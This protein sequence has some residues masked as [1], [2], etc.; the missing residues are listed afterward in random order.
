MS[1]TQAIAVPAGWLTTE[2]TMRILGRSKRRVQEWAQA[3]FLR[4]THQPFEGYTKPQRVY[5]AKDVERLKHKLTTGLK[6]PPSTSEP[7]TRPKSEPKI[8][9]AVARV[10]QESLRVM[11]P[12]GQKLWLDL[13]EA[14]QLSG[15]SRNF[16]QRLC[17]QSYHARNGDRQPLIVVRAPGYKILRKSLEAFEG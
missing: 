17:R 2:E 8:P 14:A 9:Q 3:G 7:R 10:L 6:R 11:L 16:L 1:E 4:F 15:L 5:N 13:D 12:S